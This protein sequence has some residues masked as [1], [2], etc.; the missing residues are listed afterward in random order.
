MRTLTNI[1]L[2]IFFAGLFETVEASVGGPPRRKPKG[3]NSCTIPNKRHSQA[4]LVSYR[5]GI[6]AGQNISTIASANDAMM[7]KIPGIMGGAA[8]Q[9][10]WPIG[11]TIQPEILYSKKGCVFSGS[12]LKYIIDYVE[13]PVKFMYKLNIADVKP[14]VFAAPYGGYAIKLTEDGDVA[15]DDTF[16]NMIKKGDFGVGAGAGF[17]VWKIQI[18]FKYS[19]GIA[20]VVEDTY[21]I[22]NKVFTVSVGFFF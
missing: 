17:E 20:Q 13:V 18:A 4:D 16:S 12:G 6:V 7:D 15:G 5:F 14:F 21:N 19:W 11:F 8:A 9:I 2:I 3:K 10:N 22:R 1:L